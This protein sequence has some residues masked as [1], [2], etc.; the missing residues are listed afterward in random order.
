[1]ALSL[2]VRDGDGGE[3]GREGGRRRV[4]G[5]ATCCHLSTF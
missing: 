1:M 5:G 3:G 2:Q 4:G